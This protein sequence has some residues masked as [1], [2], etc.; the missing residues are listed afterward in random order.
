MLVVGKHRA[1]MG[2]VAGSLPFVQQAAVGTAGQIVHR[3]THFA[4]QPQAEHHFGDGGIFC[5][6]FIQLQQHIGIVRVAV[7][8]QGLAAEE[9]GIIR[10]AAHQQIAIGLVAP[11]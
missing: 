5:L 1:G 10:I 7:Q 11:P 6:F 9:V 2:I 8:A 4:H 3:Q